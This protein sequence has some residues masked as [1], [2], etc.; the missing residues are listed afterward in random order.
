MS[1]NNVILYLDQNRNV[2]VLE[3]NNSIDTY[4]DFLVD[5]LFLYNFSNLT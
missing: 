1:L 4:E 3:A 5:N 2:I